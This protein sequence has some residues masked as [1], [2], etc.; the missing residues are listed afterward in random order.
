MA[1]VPATIGQPAVAARS[2]GGGVELG[3]HVVQS[4]T[5]VPAVARRQVGQHLL[6]P[7]HLHGG[8]PARCQDGAEFGWLGDLVVGTEEEMR[9]AGGGEDALSVLRKVRSLTDATLVLKRGPMGCIVF[10]GA[11]PD[12]IEDGIVGRGFPI[13]V[14]NVLGAGDAFMA[15]L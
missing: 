10:P 8:D 1:V 5:D 3:E 6:Q 2:D 13:E 14:H 15:G 12:R 7:E 9:V 11:I 4:S